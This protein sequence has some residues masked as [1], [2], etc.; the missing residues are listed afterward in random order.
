MI[1]LVIL[2][3]RFGLYFL[4]FNWEVFLCFMLREDKYFIF[5][6]L[7]NYILNGILFGVFLDVWVVLKGVI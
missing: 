4:D 7:L 3:I 1:L 5:F 6:L 2:F